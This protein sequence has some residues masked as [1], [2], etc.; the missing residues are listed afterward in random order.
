MRDFLMT[1]LSISS[2]ISRN[3]SLLEIDLW[4]LFQTDISNWS[5]VCLVPIYFAAHAEKFSVDFHSFSRSLCLSLLGASWSPCLSFL[6]LGDVFRLLLTRTC[7]G[8]ISNFAKHC[9]PVHVPVFQSSQWIY[10]T[11]AIVSFCVWQAD[12]LCQSQRRYFSKASTTL[13]CSTLLLLGIS[14]EIVCCEPVGKVDTSKR[15]QT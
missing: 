8:L 9:A 4:T 15:I 12:S 2:A 13:Y 11:D 6:R 7:Y 10:S 1:L 3:S 5:N 14:S